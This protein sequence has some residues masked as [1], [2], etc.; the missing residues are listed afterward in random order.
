MFVKYLNIL[1]LFTTIITMKISHSSRIE[2]VVDLYIPNPCQVEHQQKSQCQTWLTTQRP[3]YSYVL[4]L[5]CVH[6]VH[7]SGLLKIMILICLNSTTV[8]RMCLHAWFGLKTIE[9]ICLDC[10]QLFMSN[11]SSQRHWY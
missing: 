11:W 2:L 3:W 9:L 6:T 4:N 1:L 7:L 10:V 5:Y 8:Y